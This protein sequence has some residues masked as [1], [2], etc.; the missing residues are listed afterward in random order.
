MTMT[1]HFKDAKAADTVARAL[2]FV[3]RFSKKQAL[4]KFSD[5]S[6]SVIWGGSPKTYYI[7]AEAAA[8][9]LWRN[10]KEFKHFG[11]DHCN[12]IQV[13]PTV[14]G[15]TLRGGL[16]DRAIS[17]R[18]MRPNK[19]QVRVIFHDSSVMTHTI[20]CD[21]KTLDDY[22]SM[23]IGEIEGRLCRYNTRSYLDSVHKF[24]NIIES[25]VKL[26]TTK[27]YLW[28]KQAECGN[29][30]TVQAKNSGSDVTVSITDLDDGFEELPKQNDDYVL[31]AFMDQP[32][33]SD[34]GVLI[35]TKRITSFLSGLMAPRRSRI[36]LDI[37]HNK[38]LKVTMDN[39]SV[40]GEKFYQSI[41][42]L[43]SLA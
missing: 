37:E 41:L 26:N 4:V 9:D 43:H 27:I 33:R 2:L 40:Q 11:L 10:K 3:A 25:F 8:V 39:D 6:V 18:I 5:S 38:C 29:N 7:H 28:S 31:E 36:C 19:L 24:R 17:L 13:D 1:Y 14:L 21:M 16:Q 20:P 12:V 15:K 23:L 30:L 32:R 42:L 35:D 22:R 34:A